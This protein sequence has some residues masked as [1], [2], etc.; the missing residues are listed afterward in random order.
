MWRRLTPGD[1]CEGDGVGKD[2]EVAK[3]DDGICWGAGD[4]DFDTQVAVEA[5]GEVGP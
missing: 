2:K 4:L 5:V 3:C 1:W